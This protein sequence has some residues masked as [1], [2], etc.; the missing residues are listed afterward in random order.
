MY[1]INKSIVLNGTT[2]S[3]S[4]AYNVAPKNSEYSKKIQKE[5]SS[6]EAYVQQSVY[7]LAKVVSSQKNYQ[8][9][10]WNSLSTGNAQSSLFTALRSAWSLRKDHLN[11]IAPTPPTPPSGPNPNL[12][13]V[14]LP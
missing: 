10:L 14:P 4:N 1:K 9:E 5:A 11:P 7:D 8:V 12:P 13:N 3:P 6:S 2:V